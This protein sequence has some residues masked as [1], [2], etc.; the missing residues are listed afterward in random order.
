[1]KEK[2]IDF[3]EY[4]NLDRFMGAFL[5]ACFMTSIGFGFFYVLGWYSIL[6]IIWLLGLA[7]VFYHIE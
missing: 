1:M 2:I 4:F 7:L 5:V 3:F 6:L